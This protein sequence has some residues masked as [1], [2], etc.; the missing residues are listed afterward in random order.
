LAIYAAALSTFVFLWNVLQSKAKV[1]VDLIYGIEGEGD[2]L[3]SGVYVFV[4]NL[5]SHQIHLSSLSLLYPYRPVSLK[6]RITH[7]WEYKRFP[8]RIGWVSTSL[9]NYSIEDGC[10]ICLEPRKSHSVLI[11]DDKL[12]DVL[13]D[14]VDRTLIACVQDQLWNNTYSKVFT[15]SVVKTDEN[16]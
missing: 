7:L 8:Y 4:R 11:R 3:K 12:E 14:A 10:P 13:S 15:H 16:A 5:S 2:D 9:S 1:K 6:E